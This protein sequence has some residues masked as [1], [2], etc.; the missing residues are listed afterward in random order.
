MMLYTDN[1][2]GRNGA[3]DP[4]V[5]KF[6]E[7]YLLYYSIMPPLGDAGQGWDIGIAESTDLENWTKSLGVLVRRKKKESVHQEP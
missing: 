5:V 2:R 3:K 7:K 6:H 1:S 4:A